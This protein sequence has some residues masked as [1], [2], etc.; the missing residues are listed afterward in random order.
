MPSHRFFQFLQSFC[1]FPV[2]GLAAVLLSWIILDSFPAFSQTHFSMTAFLRCTRDEAIMKAF[3]LMQNGHGESSL[4][5]IV[6]KPMRVIFKDMKAIN[7][8][9][10]NY[11]ALS[12]ISSHGEQ[13]I[14]V[15]EKHRGAPPEALAALIAHEAMHEDEFNS[16]S[17]EIQ[18][19]RHEAVVWMEM[20]ARNPELAKIPPGLYPLVDR[21]NRIESE[22]RKHSLDNFVRSSPGYQGLPEAS[23]GFGATSASK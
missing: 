19:W 20:K 15:N 18:S 5:R 9:L 12:W 10:R 1:R 14:F 3:S 13:V 23:P 22:Y 21:E 11:D 16:I 4:T 8:S 17:E 2:V 6:N 7:K